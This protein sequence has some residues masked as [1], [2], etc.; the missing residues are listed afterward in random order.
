MTMYGSTRL[1]VVLALAMAALP[2]CGAGRPG[3]TP[4]TT[5]NGAQGGLI[6][7]GAVAGAATQPA[8]MARL[9]DSVQ[10]QCG[11]K[12]QIGR[13]FSFRGTASVG[14]FF[15]VTNRPQGNR[16]V[17]GLVIAS[18]TGPGAVEAAL[19][20]DD[21][22]RFGK[23]VN[24]MIKQLFEA[25]H[26]EA[27]AAPARAPGGASPAGAPAPALTPVTLADRTARV[28]VPAGWQVDPK[29]GGG[30]V[31]LRGPRGEVV[32]LGSMFLAQ[33]PRGPA[34]RNSQ[35]MGMRPLRGTVIF[36]ADADLVKNFAP[37]IR[38][39][40][41]ANGFTPASLRIDYAEAVAPPAG[42]SFQGERAALATGWIDP[43]GKGRQYMFRVVGAVPPDPYGDFSFHD[44]AA[45]FP[46]TEP[47]QANAIASAIFSSFQVDQALVAQRA[48][49]E[50][51]PHIARLKQVDAA[52]R[53]AVQ[54]NSARIIGNIN[55]IGANAT[56]R[57]NA[58]GQANAAQHE[59]WNA[60]QDA[61]SRN[62]QGFSN[63]LLDQRVVQ[64]NDLYGNG[65]GTAGH[66][67]LWNSTA[68]ALVK[69]DP[70]RFETVDKPNFWQGT[71]YVR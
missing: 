34:Y 51:A 44:Y 13:V 47:G 3:P 16:R 23:T 35:R 49:A 17:A 57:M 19:L 55:Q 6:V 5:L 27:P 12:P 41:R 29:S 14:V 20:T 54:A 33:D 62:I 38:E 59:Q 43:D 56:A 22:A 64:D 50:A 67:T 15:S 37:I 26:P 70:N 2:A 40:A 65:S 28:G 45:Y 25:W 61:S 63:Y 18:V 36:P 7:Y 8:A 48:S 68:D 11:E 71:D 46:S 32:V 24:P 10:A 53:Q 42:S 30:G 66:G 69:A 4:Q 1:S 31:L 21:A 60:G 39:L 52:Q 9:L 58:V